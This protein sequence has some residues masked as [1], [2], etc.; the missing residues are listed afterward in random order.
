AVQGGAIQ[1]FPPSD[2]GFFHELLSGVR[3]TALG[4]TDAA[5]PALAPLGALSWLL[6]GSTDLAQKALL[7][8]LPPLAGLTFYRALLSQAGRRV[9]A[10]VG[11]VCYGLSPVMLWAFSEGRIPVL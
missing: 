9:P 3:T 2:S 5:S 11:A 8:L 4:G 10:L 6:F 1:A 7:I